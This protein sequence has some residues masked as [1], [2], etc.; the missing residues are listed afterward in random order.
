MNTD[1][2]MGASQGP[3][4]VPAETSEAP[5]GAKSSVDKD[6]HGA[7]QQE[8]LYF[9]FAS[10]EEWEFASWLLRSGLGLSAI[11]HLLS[12]DLVCLM[13]L[14]EPANSDHIPAQAHTSLFSDGKITTNPSRNVT[15]WICLCFRNRTA[16][17]PDE[18][19]CPQSRYQRGWS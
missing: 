16:R 14:H 15:F 8:N 18:G 12:L 1:D 3:S 10:R 2:E 17:G 19:R 9:P 11:D 6:E 4:E 13:S 5:A 7:Q